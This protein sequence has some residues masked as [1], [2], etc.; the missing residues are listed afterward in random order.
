MMDLMGLSWRPLGSTWGHIAQLVARYI[1]IYINRSRPLE[2]APEAR[3][4]PSDDGRGVGPPA[5]EGPPS[6]LGGEG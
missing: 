6:G 5:S 1:Y 4:W 3:R 2:L